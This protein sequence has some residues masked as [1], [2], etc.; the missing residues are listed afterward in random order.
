V[1]SRVLIS[2]C[3]LLAFAGPSIAQDDLRGKEKK[4]D[5]V[6][7][8]MS[9][10]NY[11]I[12]FESAVPKG[13]IDKIGKELED[14]L[15]EYIRVFKVKPTEKFV[16]KFMDS[17][18]TYKQEGGD[19]SHPGMYIEKPGEKYLLI[20]QMP[21]YDLIPIT[22]HEAFHQYASM[23]MGD[24]RMPTWFNEGMA[25]YYEAV[26]RNDDDKL[27]LSLIYNRKLRMVQSAIRTRSQ[28][29]LEPLI[30]STYE[31]FHDKDKESLHYTQSFAFIYFLM[32]AK[33]GKPVFAYAKELKKT[34]DPE[35]ALAKILGRDRKKLKKTEKSF[36][37]FTRAEKLV[38][39][40]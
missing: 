16:V 9:T 1:V 14:V 8:E 3:G 28:L 39:K 22:Y 30:D 24:S 21:W 26:L 11:T 37:G 4:I 12:K 29:K 36:L 32:R 10:K 13:T 31:D 25:S 2:L 33:K 15:V 17:P 35:K 27:D 5:I 34:G 20:Q 23:Y 18:N 7:K 6:W 40:R 38:D 19:K